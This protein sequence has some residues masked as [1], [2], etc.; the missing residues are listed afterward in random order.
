[1]ELAKIFGS[2]MILQ[3]EKPILF[4]G[5][6]KGIIKI[7]FDGKIHEKTVTDEKWVVE[8]PSCRG[9]GESCDISFDLNGKKRFYMM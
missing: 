6:G 9:Y 1:M 8:L 7:F 5:T 4:F 3:A 2:G